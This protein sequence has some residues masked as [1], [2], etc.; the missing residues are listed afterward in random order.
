MAREVI[1]LPEPDSPTRPTTSP[2]AMEKLRSRTAEEHW[3][4]ARARTR[5]NGELDVQV[6]DFGAEAAR[7]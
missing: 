5:L 7:P 4:V 6:A 1:D 3:R 2:G